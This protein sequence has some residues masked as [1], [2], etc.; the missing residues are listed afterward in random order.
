MAILYVALGS[1]LGD[2]AAHL[3]AGVAGCSAHGIALRRLS[4]IYET[5]PVGGPAGQNWYLNA[6]GEFQSGL[7]ARVVLQILRNIEERNGRVRG[8]KD[9][10][11]TLDLDILS[12]GSEIRSGEDLTLP[13]P[14]L[15]LRRFVLEPFVEIAPAYRVPGLDRTAAELLADL[16]L[17]EPGCGSIRLY[18]AQ[19][20]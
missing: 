20:P 15:H 16:L 6:V 4:S 8:A 19:R 14:R 2:R 7:D 3:L 9:A 13:H 11:R 10:P 18:H 5:A 17:R 12:V 1:N